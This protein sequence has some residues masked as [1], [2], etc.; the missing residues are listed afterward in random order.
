MATTT[1]KLAR[2]LSRQQHVTNA[3]R[4]EFS[5]LLTPTEEFP[6]IPA[7]FPSAGSASSASVTTLSNG[8][9][10]VS[11]NASSTSTI[12][13]TY[14]NA[15]SSS[16]SPSESGAAL[17]NKFLAFKSGSGLSSP[18]ILRNVEN[19]GATPFATV[20]RL[21]ATVGYTASKDQAIRLVPLIATTC[22][23][24]KWDVRDAKAF[25][26]T[27]AEDAS[28]DAMSVVSDSIFSAAYGAQSTMG[29]SL[30][31]DA[32]SSSLV[33]IQS[34][35]H[36]TYGLNG[37][38]LA[39]TGIDD[40]ESF[41][42]AVEE[43]FSESYVG[44]APSEAT[45][46]PF[47]GGETRVSAPSPD[48]VAHI[49]LAFQGPKDS[50]PLLNIV[51]QCIEMSADGVSAYASSKTGLV[52]LYASSTDGAAVTDQLCSVMTSVPSADVIT[53]AKNLAKAKA[54]FSIDGGND[55]QSLAGVMTESVLES[56]LFGYGDVAAAYDAVSVDQVQILFT[57]LGGSTPAMAAVG[58]LSSVPYQGTIA[59]RFS[60]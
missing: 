25:A 32:G 6:G 39:A 23:F 47:I 20:D 9:T 17:I 27:D 37:A 19:A 13:L 3:G 55:S 21:S 4:R 59:T 18:V 1:S 56:G 54:L 15:G 29:K 2:V 33:G 58:N 38:I 48:A 10:V 45:S 34:F 50:T 41:V 14:P 36:K 11:E 53:R 49:A 7:T 24:A 51:Q 28:A 35:R 42:K 46:S 52:G 16:E 12:A 22:E 40:H 57:A 26:K 5:A 44:D 43:G 60:S 31:D 30:Y 8:L